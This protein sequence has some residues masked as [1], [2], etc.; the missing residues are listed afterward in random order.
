M[1]SR[2]RLGHEV[3]GV[4]AFKL[5]YT[6]TRLFQSDGQFGCESRGLPRLQESVRVLEDAR[7]GQ[8][9]EDDAEYVIG[10][11]HPCGGIRFVK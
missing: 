3:V 2:E 1:V 8:Y 6:A 9:A 11:R 10:R 5:L 4:L 7:E